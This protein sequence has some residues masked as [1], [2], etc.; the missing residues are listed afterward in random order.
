MAGLVLTVLA[1]DDF[2]GPPAEIETVVEPIL[3]ALLD[4]I[5]SRSPTMP[6]HIWMAPRL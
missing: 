1:I 3:G 5:A 2:V 4:G 6:A